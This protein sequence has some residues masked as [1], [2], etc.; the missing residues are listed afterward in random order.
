MFV[1]QINYNVTNSL[2]TSIFIYTYNVRRYSYMLYTEG[3]CGGNG[4]IQMKTQ[5]MGGNLGI[6]RKCVGNGWKFLGG[7]ND[8]Q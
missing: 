1:Q 2:Q 8:Q 6:R 4:H 7:T 3:K 5:K